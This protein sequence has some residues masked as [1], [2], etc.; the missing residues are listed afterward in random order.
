MFTPRK[1]SNRKGGKKPRKGKARMYD[2]RRPIFSKRALQDDVEK[3]WAAVGTWFLGPKAE[4]AD[5]FTDLMTEA[6]NSHFNFRKRLHFIC[7]YLQ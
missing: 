2:H 3:P 7:F 5:V 4:N 6:I 1:K